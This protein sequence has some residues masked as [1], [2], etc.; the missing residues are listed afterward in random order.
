M[1][2]PKHFGAITRPPRSLAEITLVLS[3]VLIFVFLGVARPPIVFYAL[4][5]APIA[6]AVM[7]YEFVVHNLISLMHH[8]ACFLRNW[9]RCSGLS[10]GTGPYR[11]GILQLLSKKR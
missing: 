8:L 10:P 11:S 6:L 4:A 3:L 7:L 5:V 1:W 9:P 2:L